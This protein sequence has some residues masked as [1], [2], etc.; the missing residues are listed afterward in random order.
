MFMA[1]MAWR[2]SR[3][4]RQRLLLFAL[5]IVVGISAL[6]AIGSFGRSLEAAVADQA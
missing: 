6:V 3:A 2:D 4:S 1:R 5:C